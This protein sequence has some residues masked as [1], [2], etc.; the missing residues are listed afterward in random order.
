M[1]GDV[2][3]MAVNWVQEASSI[4][5]KTSYECTT[6]VLVVHYMLGHTENS[7][8]KYRSMHFDTHEQTPLSRSMLGLTWLCGVKDLV[9][10]KLSFGLFPRHMQLG[11]TLDFGTKSPWRWNCTE[12]NTQNKQ[13]YTLS[14]IKNAANIWMMYELIKDPCHAPQTLFSH[15]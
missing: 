6:C 11:G 5:Q 1:A 7:P 2:A 13:L 12:K 4:Q 3:K 15:Y 10:V 8:C 14:V 9:A